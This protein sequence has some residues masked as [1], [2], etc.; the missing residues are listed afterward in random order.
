MIFS[1]RQPQPQNSCPSNGKSSWEEPGQVKNCSRCSLENIAFLARG[2]QISTTRTHLISKTLPEWSGKSSGVGAGGQNRDPEVVVFSSPVFLSWASSATYV[3]IYACVVNSLH[4]K[5]WDAHGYTEG[6]VC[7]PKVKQS[8]P[9]TTALWASSLKRDNWE[10]F[11]FTAA[12]ADICGGAA[13]VHNQHRPNCSWKYKRISKKLLP[14]LVWISVKFLTFCAVL[15]I[16]GLRA[17]R[18]TAQLQWSRHFE[19][20][21]AVRTHIASRNFRSWLCKGQE[22][23]AKSDLN[24]G[25]LRC[26]FIQLL[27]MARIGAEQ[28]M[29]VSSR[30]KTWQHDDPFNL[31]CSYH[32]HWSTWSLVFWMYLGGAHRKE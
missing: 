18:N 1:D 20:Q 10:T 2:N 23:A 11:F 12:G 29:R 22:K 3:E 7:P 32:L 27:S 14:D 31:L 19:A 16:F 9:L 4:V 26:L 8:K 5:L 6:A 30:S 24:W 13:P 28:Q 17:R 15:S 21:S 25:L